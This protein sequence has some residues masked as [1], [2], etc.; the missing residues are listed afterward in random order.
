MKDDVVGICLR[1]DAGVAPTLVKRRRQRL[2]GKGTKKYPD[3][4]RKS[5]VLLIDANPIENVSQFFADIGGSLKSDAQAVGY[6]GRLD[7]RFGWR[8]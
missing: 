8:L 2:T 7:S 6:K 1:H 3:K 5:L 4:V